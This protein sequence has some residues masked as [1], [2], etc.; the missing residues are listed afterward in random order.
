MVPLLNNSKICKLAR[1]SLAIQFRNSMADTL[2]GDVGRLFVTAGCTEYISWGNGLLRHQAL[3]LGGRKT[4]GLELSEA[5]IRSIVG[6]TA[7]S[8]EVQLETSQALRRAFSSDRSRKQ[9]KDLLL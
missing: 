4:F 9:G 6:P 8:A 2:A 5:R 1:N 3:T 7:I